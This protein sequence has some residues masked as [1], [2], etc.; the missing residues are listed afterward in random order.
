MRRYSIFH[1]PTHMQTLQISFDVCSSFSCLFVCLFV[2]CS[3]CCI[4]ASQRWTVQRRVSCAG[5]RWVTRHLRGEGRGGEG[6]GGGRGGEGRGGEGRGGEERGGE[7]RGGEEGEGRI[8]SFRYTLL[9]KSSVPSSSY[10]LVSVS[11]LPSRRR[12]ASGGGGGG[13]NNDNRCKLPTR[14]LLHN[15]TLYTHVHYIY[16]HVHKYTS[17]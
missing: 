10:S 2:C 8:N 12:L 14:T 15:Y 4:L 7:G 1:V 9:E 3:T 17:A 6:R 16:I 11:T 13:D 5:S